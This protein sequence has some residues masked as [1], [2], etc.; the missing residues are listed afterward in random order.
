MGINKEKNGKRCAS[1]LAALLAAACLAGCTGDRAAQQMAYRQTGLDAM[2]SGDYAGA[3]AAFDTALSYAP[4]TV[5][6]VELDICYYKAAAQF[7]AGDQEGALATYDALIAYDD[8]DA[9]AYYTRGCLHLQRYEGDQAFADF[10]AAISNDADNYELYMNIYRNLAA[11]NLIAEGEEYLNKAFAIKGDD[12]EQLTSRGELYLLLG[13]YENAITE[14]T[15]ALEKKSVR[16]NLILAE[17]YEASGDAEN[18]EKY[19]K[20][21]A[22]SGA[23]DS[24]TMNALAEIEMAKLDYTAA[25]DYVNQG[26][27]MEQVTNRRE[28]M[29]N[30]IIC[31]EYTADFKGAWQVAQEYIALYPNDAAVQREYVFLKNRQT[32]TAGNE[33]E[34]EIE[35]EITPAEGGESVTDTEAGAQ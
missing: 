20:A 26:L 15:A 28:L 17:V 12:A 31:M 14:L 21:Y 1:V 24:E 23:A 8:K 9:D 4:G 18:A 22:E 32:E 7:A 27:A 10:D 5:G 13:E 3:V 16:A 2:R 35:A 11:Y 30:Q 25:L 33:T 29:Q 34:T 19:Y 6:E